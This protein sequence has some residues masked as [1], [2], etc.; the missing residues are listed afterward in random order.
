MKSTNMWDPIAIGTGTVRETEAKRDIETWKMAGTTETE[1]ITDTE[2]R[3]MIG[4]EGRGITGRMGG[5]ATGRGRTGEEGAVGM[6]GMAATTEVQ[7]E[8]DIE[9]EDS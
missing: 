5:V 9:V 7:T 4:R 2:W 3:G 8:I 6:V 1:N